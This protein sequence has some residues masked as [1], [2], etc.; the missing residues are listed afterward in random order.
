MV[1]FSDFE[2]LLETYHVAYV[3]PESGIKKKFRVVGAKDHH[4]AKRIVAQKLGLPN[5]R[6]VRSKIHRPMFGK[7]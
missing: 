4:S 5:T 2:P 6:N 3:H 7:K 1:R